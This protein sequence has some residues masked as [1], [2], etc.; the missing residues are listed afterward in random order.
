M[1]DWR[2]FPYWM[3]AFLVLTAAITVW[4]FDVIRHRPYWGAAMG[5][6]A[7]AEAIRHPGLAD[8]V[9]PSSPAPAMYQNSF[10]PYIVA[11]LASILPS[12]DY[13]IVVLRILNFACA[14]LTVLLFV[15][16]LRL[17]LGWSSSMIAA[18]AVLTTP[19]FVTQ[20]ELLGPE[21]FLSAAMML[22]TF[23]LLRGYGVLATLVGLVAFFAKWTAIAW[24]PAA[25][26]Y[27]VLE[28]IRRGRTESGAFVPVSGLLA[29]V[30][31]LAVAAGILYSR[32]IPGL[33]FGG[34][35][36]NEAFGT[37]SVWNSWM[38]CPD[39]LVLAAALILLV[40]TKAQW[41]LSRTQKDG[42]VEKKSLST[43]SSSVLEQPFSLC[44]PLIFVA[45]LTMGVT[46]AVP[47][48]FVFV[49]PF[50]WMALA[51]LLLE[52]ERWNLAGMIACY[53]VVGFNL[54]NSTGQLLPAWPRIEA[55][56]AKGT[57]PSPDTRTGALLERSREYISDYIATE[58]AITAAFVAAARESADPSKRVAVAAPAPFVH[59]LALPSLG[60][61]SPVPIEGY[62]LSPFTFPKFPSLE[63]LKEVE[64]SRTS[65]TWASW[66]SGARRRQQELILVVT[67]VKNRYTD[68]S[69]SSLAW[70]VPPPPVSPHRLAPVTMLYR[71]PPEGR[72]TL[73]VY[74]PHRLP[75]A[76]EESARR[77]YLTL[78][79]P[80]RAMLSTAEEYEREGDLA[81]A[82]RVLWELLETSPQNAAGRFR[83]GMVLEAK[84]DL[85][86]AIEQYR[87][88]PESSPERW[89]ALYQLAV[90]HA[91]Q[92]QL[93]RAGT[94]FEECVEACR[95]QQDV[96]PSELARV[97]MQW[98]LLDKAQRRWQEARRRI[99]MAVD[100]LKEA[101]EGS[102]QA[103][104]L[105]SNLNRE[106]GDVLLSTGNVGEAIT[107]LTAAL[108]GDA[109]DRQALRLL[110]EAYIRQKDWLQARRQFD[111]ALGV[112]PDDIA[113]LDGLATAL[114]G[115]G[116]REAALSAYRQA[117]DL[118]AEGEQKA[119]VLFGQAKSQKAMGR[120]SDAIDSLQKAV[121]AAPEYWNAVN[122]LALILATCPE[123]SLRD[124]ARAVELAR[125]IV[126]AT[127][128][129]HPA[130]V[131]TLALAYAETG[132]FHLATDT[133]E[134]ALQAAKAT[135]P[136]ELVDEIQNHL[137][138]FKAEKPYREPAV[139]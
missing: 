117:L 13:V 45:A 27:F 76:T 101:D 65:R 69:V 100:Y 58:D 114:D 106:L 84:G 42:P 124:G 95:R 116:D 98:G 15:G 138:L 125:S 88:V 21:M 9:E 107:V 18:A 89:K 87:I 130:F 136:P 5:V 112:A 92:G 17:R 75:S 74:I 10:V 35:V 53:A 32:A 80:V 48:S 50:L 60:Y 82:E 25:I 131:D 137:D 37:S 70:L 61:R 122:E 72:P 113:A 135:G 34:W 56:G 73:A 123:D 121:Q 129:P 91:N 67:Y 39:V 28:W 1:I 78:F 47:S 43:L 77:D 127:R 19:V 111:L 132:Q 139:P 22:A 51:V 90:I 81:T 63:R 29:S 11:G 99:E 108:E 71:D 57:V 38:W 110:G 49:V 7:Q 54:Y 14:S 64:Q 2:A 8:V 16:C 55:A 115:L 30:G 94:Y 103:R 105:L 12:P 109:S 120:Y 119:H 59:F 83:L 93:E 126:E 3:F 97:Y 31:A 104:T 128:E 44:V 79:R 36:P 24:F 23:L 133:A 118:G 66:M 26:A 46:G 134:R 33:P 40:A 68:R 20:V 52:S 41:D 102:P 6:F 62:S 86:A 4:R 85:A 96:G